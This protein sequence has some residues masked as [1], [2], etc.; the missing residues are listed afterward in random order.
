MHS[1]IVLSVYSAGW[2]TSSVTL[3]VWVREL[4]NIGSARVSHSWTFLP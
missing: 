1:F 4:V 2:R 3:L